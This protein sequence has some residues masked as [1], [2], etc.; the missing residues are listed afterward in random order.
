MGVGGAVDGVGKGTPAVGHLKGSG[1]DVGGHVQ[2]GALEVVAHHPFE[3]VGRDFARRFDPEGQDLALALHDPGGPAVGLALG[4][5]A[6]EVTPHAGV[7]A[8]EG[9]GVGDGIGGREVEILVLARVEALLTGEVNHIGGIERIGIVEGEGVD[10]RV[11][12]V[13]ADAAV[14]DAACHPD[15]IL[16]GLALADEF[17]DPDLVGVG[18]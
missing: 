1:T 18:D 10:A 17:H 9:Q 8:A 12:G 4:E 13:A 5:E 6:A 3:V 7:A 14:G 11:V 15:G 16:G 2:E